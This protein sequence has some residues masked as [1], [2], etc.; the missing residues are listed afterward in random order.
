MAKKLFIGVIGLGK[1]GIALGKT[2]INM[3]YEVLG[4]DRSEEAVKKAQSIFTQVYRADVKDKKVLEQLGFKDVSHA[5]VS[6]GSSISTSSMVS[7]Y[8][9]ELGVPQVWVKAINE[10]HE[11]LLKKIGVDHVVIPERAAAQEL[12]LRMALPGFLEILPFGKSVVIQEKTVDKWDNK[13][14]REL[15]LANKYHIQV[16]AIKKD[17]KGEYKFVPKG[18]DVLNK[19]D[20]LVIIG[21][22]ENLLKVNS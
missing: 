15:D 7:F 11:K 1:F 6:V 9:K 12:A 8:L 4:V 2:L 18:N 3:G 14:L 17:G 10:D 5:V 20:V 21:E 19:G 22:M 13:T 16:I